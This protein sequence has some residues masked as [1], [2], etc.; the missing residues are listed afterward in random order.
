MSQDSDGQYSGD[1]H[2]KELVSENDLSR[3]WLAE[4]IS[5]SRTVL[6]EELK[7]ER[8]DHKESFLADVRAK[9]SVDHPLIGSIY[10][11][12]AGED[13]CF[14]AYE[15]LHGATLENHGKVGEPLPPV[16]LAKL[17]R[18]MSEAQFHLETVGYAT[19]PLNLAHIHLD[20]H[21]LL[22]F[23]NPVIAG[24]RDPGQSSQDI[25]RLGK[26]LIPLVVDGQPGTNRMLTLLAWMR[27]EGLETALDWNRVGNLCSQ[28]EQQLTGPS[29]ATTTRAMTRARRSPGARITIMIAAAAGLVIICALAVLLRPKGPPPS[30]RASLPDTVLIPGGS[31]PTPD[32]T[33]AKL[34]AFLISPHE[35]TIAQYAAFLETLETLTENKLERTFDHREQPPEKTTHLPDDWAALFA[36]ART[37]GIWNQRRVTLDTPVVGIDWWD[38]AAYAEWKKGR[39]PSQEEWFAALRL[40][41][42]KPAAIPPSDWIAVT[43]ETSDRIPPGLHGMAGSACEWTGQLAADPA[44]PLGARQWVIIGGSYLKPGSNALSREWT[45]DR[46]LR[47]ADLGFRLAF[48]AN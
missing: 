34:K 41:V 18:R 29:T 39:L 7:P 48:D 32:G 22:R 43:D 26:E 9:A 19:T 14:F 10:E 23:D 16:M 20:E 1:Y 28:I 30:P 3:S 40:K 13:R 47:R 11:A 42:E 27:G 17:L 46:S 35:V 6:V 4:Q 12:V 5:I 31:H 45:S 24:P 44:N 15:L 25:A 8:F 21:S 37:N 36:A 38:A 2:F 33:A